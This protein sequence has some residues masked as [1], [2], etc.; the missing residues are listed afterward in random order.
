L[1]PVQQIF[2]E[3]GALHMST[4]LYVSMLFRYMSAPVD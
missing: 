1:D 3:G 4:A 2:C